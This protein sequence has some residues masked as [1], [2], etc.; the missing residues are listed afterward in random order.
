MTDVEV[1]AAIDNL[2][3]E[4]RQACRAGHD[5]RAFQRDISAAVQLLDPHHFTIVPPGWTL[6]DS[7]EHGVADQHPDGSLARAL[8]QLAAANGHALIAPPGVD[9]NGQTRLL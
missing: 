1:L 8:V 4:H 6:T 7:P 2:A 3:D 5:R 9:G